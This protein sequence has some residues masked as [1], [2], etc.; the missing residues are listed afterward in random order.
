MGLSVANDMGSLCN[1][2]VKWDADTSNRFIR[3][4][5]ISICTTASL[6]QRQDRETPGLHNR[7]RFIFLLPVYPGA[8]TI[9]GKSRWNHRIWTQHEPDSQDEC[10]LLG[11]TSAKVYL[12]TFNRSRCHWLP[13]AFPGF[14]AHV[15]C[16]LWAS[17][18]VCIMT[19]AKIPYGCHV[20]LV[21]WHGKAS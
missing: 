13:A 2:S 14:S 15:P 21:Q 20:L 8:C 7:S 11:L 10:H 18:S 4:C 12:V 1:L 9:V 16:V 3:R 6:L 19:P 17:L 5:I